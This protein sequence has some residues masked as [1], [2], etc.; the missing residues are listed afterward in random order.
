M[1]KHSWLRRTAL[2]A[3]GVTA[4]TVLGATAAQASTASTS[5]DDSTI[6]VHGPWRTLAPL[7]SEIVPAHT[8][9]ADHPWLTK[10]KYAPDFV[11]L[12]PGVEVAQSEALPDRLW[13]IGI[14]ITGWELSPDPNSK[15]LNFITGT[16][17][18]P[19]DSSATNWAFRNAS[20]QLRL[21]CTD[22]P[23]E[24]GRR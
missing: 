10:E 22:D 9:P 23:A 4:A 19:L 24:A 18:G 6:V 15:S 7:Q 1:S 2:V 13:P 3:A 16:K 21:H 12:P 11:T 5:G 14:S 17:S 8:C 20:Y